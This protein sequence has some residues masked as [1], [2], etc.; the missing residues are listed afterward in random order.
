M[1]VPLLIS[2]RV[3]KIERPIRAQFKNRPNYFG[4]IA[5]DRERDKVC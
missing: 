5:L 1:I 3:P 4:H 2:F